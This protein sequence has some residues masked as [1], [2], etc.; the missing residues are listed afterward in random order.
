MRRFGRWLLWSVLALMLLTGAAGSWLYAQLRA[1]LPQLDGEQ[2]LPGLSAPV[3][4]ERDALG[5][6]TIRAADRVDAARALG[7]LHA[8]ERYFQMDLLRRSA[9]GELAELFG[10]PALDHDRR[11]RLHRFRARAERVLSDLQAGQRRQIEAY[12]EGANTGLDALSARP[13]EYLLLRAAPAPWRPADTLLAGYAMYLDLQDETGV[14]DSVRGLLRDR[15]PEAMAE[16]LDPPG[17]EWD[18]PLRGMPFA[19]PAPPGPE[20]F[21]IRDLMVS[22]PDP[23]PLDDAIPDEGSNAWA[24]AGELTGHGGALLANDMHLGLRVPNTWYRAVLV[25]PD[26]GRARR[27]VGVSLPGTPLLVIGSNGRL[28]WG[29]TNSYGDWTDLVELE[30]GR[31]DDYWTFAGPWPFVRHAEVLRVAGGEPETLE[32]IETRWGPVIDR[33]HRD[34]PRA[35]RWVAHEDRALNL[36]LIAL[37]TADSVGAALDIAA[38]IR[39][40]A[41][42]IVLADADGHIAWTIAGPIPERIG[43]DGRHPLPWRLADRCRN[44]WLAPTDYPRI[45]DP[46][47]GRIWSANAR[48]VDG[49]SLRLIGDG[50]YPPGARAGQIR[51]ALH[52]RERF[53]EAAMLA[54]QLDDRARFMARWRELLLESLDPAA[55]DSTTPA[56]NDRRS[57]LH[58]LVSDWDGRAST[59]AVGYRLVRAFRAAVAGR[60]FAP[61]QAHLRQFDPAFDYRR[62]RQREG[63]LWALVEQRPAHWLNT[64]YPDWRDLLLD[65]ADGVIAEL[66][67]EGRALAERHWGE[68]NTL[69]MQH[70]LSRALPLAG[71]WLDMPAEPLPGGVHVPRVQS[72][73]KG[74]SQR[75]VVAP[76]REE[77]GIFHMPGG[78][79]GHPLSPYYRA[80][81]AAWVRGEP[82]PLLPGPTRHRLRLSPNLQE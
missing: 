44:G 16:F 6:P 55:L 38:R 47:G 80:D 45:V 70:P 69:R 42:N 18:A 3:M 50:G 26:D 76:G 40:P 19:T 32:V 52:A 58:R 61:L 21:R 53:D 1:S 31:D 75:L 78:Q 22:I 73:A 37:E 51:D 14:L 15:L 29:L 24:V 8:Q 33:D 13:F 54:I 46:P 56:E 59:D 20:I 49:P 57:E 25:Y 36:G 34:R 63:P 48:M 35:L 43:C 10:P 72:P 74:A 39:I 60:V 7:F 62:I 81:H 41:Q 5:V 27:V 64:N 17:N 65:A 82:T 77:Q 67:A 28:A 9:A 11:I 71:R 66:T 79:S 2:V 12:V 23:Q 30:P 4:V 68:R